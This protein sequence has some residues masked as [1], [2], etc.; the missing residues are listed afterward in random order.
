[1]KEHHHIPIRFCN[2]RIHL[3]QW[4]HRKNRMKEDNL[5]V[6]LHNRPDLNV[7]DNIM[8]QMMSD[9]IKHNDETLRLLEKP[10]FDSDQ[11]IEELCVSDSI[12]LKLAY[13]KKAQE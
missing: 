10:I 13:S 12:V 6:T 2:T 7:Y 8:R 1:M 11:S 5:R 9:S 4:Y 3:Y